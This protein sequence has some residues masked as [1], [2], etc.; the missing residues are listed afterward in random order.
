MVQ[1]ILTQFEPQCSQSELCAL[2]HLSSPPPQ[3]RSTGDLPPPVPSPHQVSARAPVCG[4]VERARQ[5]EL[6]QHCRPQHAV[7]SADQRVALAAKVDLVEVAHG[8]REL[9]G[10]LEHGTVHCVQRLGGAAIVGIVG[11][12]AALAVAL[13]AHV[14]KEEVHEAVGVVQCARRLEAQPPGA[15]LD[16]GNRRAR[17]KQRGCQRRQHARW[18]ARL[19]TRPRRQLLQQARHLRQRALLQ[20]QQLLRR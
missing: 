14:P 1:G 19:A 8:R 10:V 7:A 15:H 20:H 3:S 5:F 13:W 9:A 11:L 18:A 4:H 16:T 12:V 6:L 17:A 2:C